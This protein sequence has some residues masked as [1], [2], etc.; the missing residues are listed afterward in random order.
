MNKRNAALEAI[1]GTPAPQAT[2]VPMTVEPAAQAVE[3]V[4]DKAPE[5]KV[6]PSKAVTK[7]MVY[8]PSKVA[9]KFKEIAFTEERK[10]NDVYLEALDLY[11]A[12]HG[13][14]GVKAVSSR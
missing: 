4:P 12:K 7:V 14:G 6:R 11:L 3:A 13:H 9:R 2:V 8:M 10:A 5:S 1:G